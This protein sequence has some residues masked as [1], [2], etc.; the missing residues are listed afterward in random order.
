MQLSNYGT[1]SGQPHEM[2]NFMTAAQRR[3]QEAYERIQQRAKEDPGTA[4]DQGEENWAEFLRVWLP[5]YFQVVTK[6]R[7]LSPSGIASS[8]VDVLVLV[9]SYPKGLLSEKL[10]LAAGVAAAFECKTTLKADHIQSAMQ[11]CA[12]IQRAMPQR[13]GTPYNELNSSFVFGLLAHS[14]SWKAENSKPVEN[15]GNT[16]FEANGR[17]VKH[18]REAMDFLCV[19]DLG[20]W[21]MTKI[22]SVSPQNFPTPELA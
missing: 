7:I 8:Q 13:N 18:P 4:G 12:E 10:Y 2:H 20:T 9:P 6:G 3:M 11:T 5:P 21:S 22:N 17:I 15:I 16:L 1:S 19:A 14:H